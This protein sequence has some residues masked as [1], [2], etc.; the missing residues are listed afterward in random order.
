MFYE[1]VRAIVDRAAELLP[2]PPHPR[3]SGAY[4]RWAE[5]VADTGRRLARILDSDTDLIRSLL[6]DERNEQNEHSGPAP[7]HQ[8]R[9]LLL[10]VALLAALEMRHAESVAPRSSHPI[11]L[12]A[13]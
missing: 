10:R 1:E 4:G 8:R 7:Y 6:A 2:E 3:I 5:L 9:G 11:R 13:A 12:D